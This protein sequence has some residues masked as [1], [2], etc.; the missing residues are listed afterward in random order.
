MAGNAV[1]VHITRTNKL[2][3]RNILPQTEV[4]TFVIAS[5]HPAQVH[6]EALTCRL[7]F[8]GGQVFFC[9]VRMSGMGVALAPVAAQEVIQMM[10]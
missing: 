7:A 5:Y 4:N 10:R 9:A 3:R 2:R 8:R 6:V 1:D